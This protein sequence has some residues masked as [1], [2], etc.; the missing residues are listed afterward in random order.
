MTKRKDQTSW[1]YF[2]LK[3]RKGRWGVGSHL[4]NFKNQ[5]TRYASG[6]CL[7]LKQRERRMNLLR[8]LLALHFS[9]IWKWIDPSK[10]QQILIS[11]GGHPSNSATFPADLSPE[12][13]HLFPF[14]K[15]LPTLWCPEHQVQ[16]IK[17]FIYL[18]QI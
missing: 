18:S 17:F 14:Q 5:I 4:K 3:Q 10:Q 12:C 2:S 7:H 16:N 11:R 15:I 8:S 13:C 6:I 9:R 1:A